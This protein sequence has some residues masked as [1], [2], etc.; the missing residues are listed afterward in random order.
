MKEL[1]KENCKEN[2][3]KRQKK[4]KICSGEVKNA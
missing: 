4:R 1:L 3:I 2:E